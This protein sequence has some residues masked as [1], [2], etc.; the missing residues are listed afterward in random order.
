MRV[1]RAGELELPAFFC[2]DQRRVSVARVG[3][4][5][6]RKGWGPLLVPKQASFEGFLAGTGPAG[7]VRS[8]SGPTAAG[9]RSSPF[10][11]SAIRGNLSSE[12]AAISADGRF[13][14][15]ES[16]A[17]NL[18]PGDNNAT[19]DVFVHDRQTG[20]TWR[21]SESSHGQEG[22]DQSFDAAISADG[23]YI[24]F[25]SRASNLVVDD[26]NGVADLFLHELLTGQTV[27]V[28]HGAGGFET[29]GDSLNPHLAGPDAQFIVFESDASNISAADVN[30]VRD[31]YMFSRS[32]GATVAVSVLP[33][34]ET[35]DGASGAPMVSEDGRYIVFESLAA[36][37]VAEDNNGESDVFVR[38]MRTGTT[39]MRSIDSEGVQGNA[40]STR[41]RLTPDGRLVV[42]ESKATNLT[43]DPVS[44]FSDIFIRSLAE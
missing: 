34:G 33:S 29:D 36:D 7:R 28:S 13:I 24:V 32:T 35:G 37:L 30:G 11:R 41:P 3:Y 20:Q 12:N 1:G 31:V 19:R 22:N 4:P 2:A 39:M 15:F 5:F 9:R 8:G 42:F 10:C 27:R 18:V 21:V 25:A 14:V 17:D 38:D 26:T 44:N 6:R 23:A 40:G 43:E 16:M